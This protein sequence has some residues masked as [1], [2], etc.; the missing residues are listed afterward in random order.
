MKYL[1]EN[2]KAQNEENKNIL[3]KMLKIKKILFKMIT[4]NYYN[5]LKR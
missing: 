3:A 1:A 5:E 2:L 4:K